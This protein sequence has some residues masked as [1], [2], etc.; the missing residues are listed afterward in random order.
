LTAEEREFIHRFALLPE[1]S[2]ALLVRM[3]MRRGMF[4]RLSRLEYPEIGDAA[5]AAATLLDMGWLEEPLLDVEALHRLLTKAELV[6]NL[7]LPRDVCRLNK[8]DLLEVLRAQHTEPRAF[9]NWCAKLKDRVFRPAVKPLAE[10]FQLMF[11]GNFHQ[12]WTAFVLSDLGISSYE[13]VPVHSAPFRTRTHIESFHQLYRLA[14]KR[15]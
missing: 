2:S 1:P 11:F 4:F 12:D 3:I 10:R 6:R 8:P 5:A 7:T 9:H 14:G 15:N 13:N